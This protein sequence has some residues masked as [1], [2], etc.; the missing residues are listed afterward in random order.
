MECSKFCP[1][2]AA[3]CSGL[4]GFFDVARKQCSMVSIADSLHDIEESTNGINCYMEDVPA[5]LNDVC[6]GLT[7]IHNAV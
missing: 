7:A 5:L 4:C 1:F 6:A 3:N 2:R